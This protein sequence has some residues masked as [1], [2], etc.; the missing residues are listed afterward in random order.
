MMFEKLFSP[1]EIRGMHLDNR[2][3]FPAM[4]TKMA[5]ED[6]NV[7]QQIIDYQVARVK[8]GCGLNL[9]EVCA[10][11]APSAPRKFLGIHNDSMIASHKRFTDAIHEA[12]GKCGVQLWQGSIAAGMDPKAQILVASD[13]NVHGYTI[14]GVTIETLHEVAA[15]FGTAAA[16]S[17]EAGYD[18][19]EF[20]C[21]HNYLP[22]SMLSPGLNHREDE[23]GGSFENRAKFPLECIRAIRANMPQDM[24][25]LMRIDA[26]DDYFEQGLSIEDII[27]FC[28][29]AKEAGVDVLDVS[30]GNM[31]TAGLKY[32]VPPIDIPNGFNV[33]N[34]ARIRKE[35]GMLTIAVGR[36]NTPQLAQSILEEDKADMIVMGRAQLADAAFC[37]KAKEGKLKDITYCIGCDQGCYDGFTDPSLPF[38]TCLRNPYLGRE[39]EDVLHPAKTSKKVL[40][41]GGGIAGLEAACILKQ[42]GHEPVVYEAS[43]GLGGQFVTAGKAPRKEE[44][45]EAALSYGEKAK[46]LG[47]KINLNTKADEALIEQEKPDEVIIAIGAD[48]IKLPIKGA[49]L[50]HVYAS[51]D[52]LNEAVEPVGTCVVIGGGL[53]GV[54]TAEY[55]KENKQL[56]VTIVEMQEAV[57]KDLGAL[58]KIC[59]M[60]SLYKNQIKTVVNATVKSI[61]EHSVIIEKEGK[62]E[63]I[64]C[65]SV[66]MAVGSKARDHKELTDICEKLS[67]PCHIIGDA[68]QARRALQAI[69][70]AHDI[71]RAI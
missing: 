27:A 26:Q 60:E 56:D 59:V 71:A 67:I 53:V 48:P 45:L 7:S 3:V 24:P 29:L 47:V 22:H 5:L 62:E 40:I 12:G 18:C 1:I 54:E 58:R 33:D 34:A 2:V 11:H 6:G 52:V 70:E 28:K 17:V 13:M 32:E 4:G 64:Q 37:N 51:H 35:T 30:R 23:Y 66:I 16:R 44:M 42:R 39:T 41:A 31:I 8:G 69:K 46:R 57:A 25:L 50:S 19:I 55:L 63:S 68:K 36:I 61:K 21:A 10:V 38:I 20:H 65:D 15:C 9:S 43:D 49:D 14:P